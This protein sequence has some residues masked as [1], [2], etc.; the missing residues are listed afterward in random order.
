[1][2]NDIKYTLTVSDKY[3][4]VIFKSL[5]WFLCAQTGQ[6]SKMAEEIEK[7]EFEY[8]PGNENNADEL[9]AYMTRR[10]NAIKLMQE[11]FFVARDGKLP[12][13]DTEEVLLAQDV[14][15]AIRHKLW[16]DSPEPKSHNT[17]AALKPTPLTG[18]DMPHIV[19]FR[20][21]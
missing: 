8:S 16:L 4:H 7:C 20:K 2:K 21:V 3:L 9:E 19:T 10:D 17:I 5:E 6:F 18:E 15:Y 13:N 14:W 1:M 11:A 12:V